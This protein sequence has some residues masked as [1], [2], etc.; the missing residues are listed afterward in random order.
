M[1]CQVSK[2][3]RP[4]PQQASNAACS[5]PRAAAPETSKGLTLLEESSEFSFKKSHSGSGDLSNS[6]SPQDPKSLV[7]ED[8]V[9]TP[10][11]KSPRDDA[12]EAAHLV[13]MA[14]STGTTETPVEA[15]SP[16]ASGSHAKSAGDGE[17]SW[18]SFDGDG[19]F[20]VA[21]S[22]VSIH[23][24]T[25]LPFAVSE[26]TLSNRRTGAVHINE[27]DFM[28]VQF[29]CHDHL[30]REDLP[31]DEKEAR[32]RVI[33]GDDAERVDIVLQI[34]DCSSDAPQ[35]KLTSN[36]QT[37]FPLRTNPRQS[38]RGPAE[39]REDIQHA[40]LFQ[41]SIRD[42]DEPHIYE[43]RPDR[44][45]KPNVWYSATI[46]GYQKDGLFELMA[47]M[48][49]ATG[50]MREVNFSLVDPVDIRR[51]CSA[52][53]ARKLCDPIERFLGIEVPKK[54]PERAFLN[55]DGTQK[56]TH[57]FA[58]PSPPPGSCCEHPPR[59]NM[60]V[61]KDRKTV[62]ADAPVS[63]LKHLLSGEVRKGPS[64][65]DARRHSWIVQCG[66][67]AEHFIEVERRCTSSKVVS[68]LVDETPFVESN[69]E[70]IDCYTDGW[71]CTF[72]FIGE[73]C[74]DFEV[75]ECDRSWNTL[76]STGHVLQKA[77]YTHNCVVSVP[78]LDDLT[79]ARL[80]LDDVDFEL[81]PPKALALEADVHREG[82]LSTDPDKLL[83]IHNIR[84]PYK[85]S[86]CLESSGLC[87][88]EG[89][90]MSGLSKCYFTDVCC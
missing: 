37:I 38:V 3:T 57:Y 90:V 46:A 49:D 70:D 86:D 4:T 33:I 45:S 24:T 26:K 34:S 22:R 74:L 56:I 41:G 25:P 64:Q 61:S 1:G 89:S 71:Q 16:L 44:I 9:C 6:S 80:V 47:M 54:D 73:R 42:A 81:L 18:S 2:N 31:P 84:V 77:K 78:D 15:V 62:S 82:N 52:G 51:K 55:I 43:F 59:I 35:V 29:A 50:A 67:F 8:G 32:W 5:S 28:V 17:S 27:L 79:K 12:S 53:K 39:L 13:V 40:W 65:S 88:N 63:M 60:K 14:K 20:V 10:S 72:R 83:Q 85:V 21:Q 19:S 36:G 30:F 7:F 23:E 87:H 68:L 66:P 75:Y 76:D 48:P 58:R 11:R 69:S